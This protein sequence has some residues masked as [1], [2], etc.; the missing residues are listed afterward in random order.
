LNAGAT[1]VWLTT[2]SY[3]FDTNTWYINEFR[4]YGSSLKIYI[5][6]VEQS[7][8]TDSDLTSGYV[9]LETFVNSGFEWDW[10]LVRKYVDPEPSHGSWGSV[11]IL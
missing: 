1:D 11:I 10:F 6:D 3:T 5:D 7:S 8:T 9:G 2:V 4:L